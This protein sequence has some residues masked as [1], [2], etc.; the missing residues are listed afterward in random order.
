MTTFRPLAGLAVGVTA[1]TAMSFGAFSADDAMRPLPSSELSNFSN[2]EVSSL[3][4]FT[5]NALL[6]EYFAYW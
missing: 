1:L 4:E 6:I 2:T 3:T 5:G